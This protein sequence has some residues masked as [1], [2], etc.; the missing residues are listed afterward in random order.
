MTSSIIITAAIVTS[1][2]YRTHETIAPKATTLN[3]PILIMAPAAKNTQAQQPATYTSP[4]GTPTDASHPPL[5]ALSS[6]PNDPIEGLAT[7]GD[8][9]LPA[10]PP[11]TLKD[12]SN[13]PAASVSTITVNQL[14]AIKP[15]EL[16][17][18]HLAELGI[19]SSKNGLQYAVTI[20]GLGKIRYTNGLEGNNLF[21][22]GDQSRDGKIVMNKVVIKKSDK[23]AENEPDVMVMQPKY[24][25]SDFYLAFVSQIGSTDLTNVDSLLNRKGPNG[26]N[27]STSRLQVLPVLVKQA[28]FAPFED[29]HDLVFWFTATP[30]LFDKLKD[31]NVA[32]ARVVDI[33]RTWNKSDAEFQKE[34]S[35]DPAVL[36]TIKPLDLTTEQMEKLGFAFHRHKVEYACTIAGKGS[37]DYFCGKKGMGIRVNATNDAPKEGQD[38]YP[39]FISD[40]NGVQQFKYRFNNVDD[41]DKWTKDYFV[42]AIRTLVP[43]HVVQT[44]LGLKGAKDAIF[45]FNVTPTF[46]EALPAAIAADMKKE[47]DQLSQK[48]PKT[49]PITEAPTVCKYF[50]ACQMN[51]EKDL[52][53]N[54]YP[55]PTSDKLNVDFIL[56]ANTSATLVLT[57]LA[58]RI[59]KDLGQTYSGASHQH[60][61]MMTGNTKP[62]IYLINLKLSNGIILSNR[63]LLQGQK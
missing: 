57:D 45:W 1:L 31:I 15:L 61:E 19:L 22:D 34:N 9:H 39:V 10:I 23:T 29:K 24:Q 48:E 60:A 12:P 59:I 33:T 41:K 32:D 54:V 13:P 62:G 6:L 38:F 8:L 36:Q 37:L 46:L 4:Q 58:G 50:D 2:F 26:E 25:K 30:T 27:D 20:K 52:Q 7:T 55:N 16:D 21:V 3:N 49:T 42:S 28:D 44:Q 53:I 5:M 18:A 11:I 40:M 35:L 47:Y 14:Q 51:L 56:P 17:K 63:V 43:V